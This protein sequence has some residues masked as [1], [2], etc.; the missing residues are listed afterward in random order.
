MKKCR[1]PLFLV[2]LSLFM[3]SKLVVAQQSQLIEKVEAAPKSNDISYEKWRLP[4]GLTVILHEDHSDPIVHVDVTYHVGSARESIGKSGFAHFFEHMMFQGSE[5]VADEEHFKIVSASGG[6]LN[7]NTTEDRTVY[8]ETMPS[9]YLETALW[10]ESDRMG[11]L[12]NGVT[13]KKFEVQRATVKNEKGQNVENQPYGLVPE[14]LNQ[15]LYP[16]G[17]PYSWPTI[18]YIEDLN[19]VDVKDL[20]NFFL[21]WYGPNNAIIAVTGDIKP[22]ETLK[23]IEKYFGSIN[24]CPEVKKQKV[25]APILAADQF[26]SYTDNVYFPLDLIVFP[27]VPQ[28]HRDE[29]ALDLLAAMMGD[30]NNSIFYKNFV[31]SDKAAQV[32]VS[33]SSRELAGD[34][35][36]QIVAYPYVNEKPYTFADIEKDAHEAISKFEVEGITDENLSR[37][38]TKVESQL[39]DLSSSIA[40]KATILSQWEMLLGKKYNVTDELDRYKKV[41]KEDIVRVFNKYIKD[42]HATIVNVNPRSPYAEKDSVKSNNPYANYKPA[43]DPQYIGLKY[44]K[45]VDNFDRNTHP[46]AGPAVA[47][48]VPK[49]YT[50][51]LDNGLKIIGTQNTEIPKVTLLLEIEGGDLVLD[52]T[53]KVGLANLTAAVMDESTKNF[54]TEQISAE[55]DKLGSSISFNADKQSSTIYVTSLTR[56]LDATLKLLEEKLLNPGFNKEDFDRAK[57][58]TIEGLNNRFTNAQALGQEA[59]NKLLFGATIAGTASSV[60][61]VKKITLDDV[62]AYYQKYYSPSVS[63]LVI[64]GD[65]SEAELMP[66]LAFLKKWEKKDVVIAPIIANP[67]IEKTQIFIVDK[68]KA[69]QSVMMIGESS[70]LTYDATGDYF[71]ANVMNYI[72]GGAFNSRINL[73]LR[74]DKGFTYGA[75]SGYNANKFYG[76][77]IATASVRGTATDSSVVETMKEINKYVQSG[78]NDEELAFTKTSLLS[79]DALKYETPNQKAGFLSRIAKYNLTPDYIAKQSDILKAMTKSDVNGLAKK[80][81]SPNK[82][83]IVVVGDKVKIK[84]QLEALG[85]GKAK[86]LNID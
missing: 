2:A 7:G 41:T 86:E 30:G 20:Q 34:F 78:I 19:R 68:P 79:S 50:S 59:F 21:R 85:Y 51:K 60:K 48:V 43:V 22:A 74:E 53:D 24:R 13:Q 42:K 76:S 62:K 8:F 29:P 44:I 80:Y 61:S 72:L 37:Q 54:T 55:L 11:F 17:H 6:Q 84:K 40:G 46:K 83:V 27:T 58:Q 25:D 36:I 1:K 64:V 12:V 82:M 23:L 67:V 15:T 49:Y 47:P 52:K 5:H 63:N 14:L 16:A 65:I 45:P 10:L 75:R 33:N 4:N 32:A 38:K 73:N 81:I 39:V 77:F 57:K 69:P 31:K 35:E 71:K 9:N 3:T 18:G 26:V 66:K 70:G 56:N 28:Y